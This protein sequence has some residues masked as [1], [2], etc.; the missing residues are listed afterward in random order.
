[1]AVVFSLFAF[2]LITG[3]LT[4]YLLANAASNSVKVV[5]GWWVLVGFVGTATLLAWRLGVFLFGG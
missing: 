2:V 1:M 3:W 5:V 4:S